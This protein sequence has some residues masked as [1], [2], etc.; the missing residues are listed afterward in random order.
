MIVSRS[1]FEAPE[2][3]TYPFKKLFERSP[4]IVV[5]HARDAFHAAAASKT[6]DGRLRNTLDVVA[7]DLFDHQ[8][9]T[10]IWS[11]R[12]RHVPCDGA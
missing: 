7:Q 10:P 3:Y 9:E 11:Q 5:D 2:T 6:A 8:P 12:L 4:H 1:F